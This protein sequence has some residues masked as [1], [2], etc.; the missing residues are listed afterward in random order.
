MCSA[1]TEC[2]G[3]VFYIFS[4]FQLQDFRLLYKISGNTDY[5]GITGVEGKIPQIFLKAA[6]NDIQYKFRISVYR[7][8]NRENVARSGGEVFMEMRKYLKM[9]L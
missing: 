2:R 1:H 9:I 4:A 5:I 7:H 3:I 8:V 6:L